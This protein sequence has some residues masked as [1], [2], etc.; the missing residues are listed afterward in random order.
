MIIYKKTKSKK[1]RIKI[2]KLIFEIDI[3]K[4]TG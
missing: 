3:E 2:L 1:Q 4:T